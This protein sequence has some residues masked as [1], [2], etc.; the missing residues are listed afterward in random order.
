MHQTTAFRYARDTALRTATIAAALVAVLVIS[1]VGNFTSTVRA[2]EGSAAPIK[3]AIIVGPTHGATAE[4]LVQGEQFADQ[5][6]A[7]GM[8]VTRVFHP[9]ATWAAVKTAT[10]GAN[11]VVYYGHGNGWPSP[12]APFQENSKNGF[13]LNLTAGGSSSS[14]TYYGG[15]KLRESMRLAP[16]AVTVLYRACYASGNGEEG[17]PVP[18]ESI[19]LQRV[20]N[21]AAAFLSTEVGGSAVFALGPNQYV[22]Y[23]AQLMT[24]GMTMEDI[25]RVNSTKPGYS[26]S[27]WVGTSPIYAESTRTPGAQ[28]LLDPRGSTPSTRDYYRALSGELAMTTDTWRGDAPEVGY[29]DDTVAPEVTGLT[30]VQAGDT[31]PASESSVPVFTPN[32]DGISDTMTLNHSVSEPAYLQYAIRDAGGTKVRSFAGWTEGDAGSTVWDGKDDGGAY[33]DEG[34]YE[35]SVTP[36]DRA[37]N[38]GSQ[39]STS[40]K[41]LKSMKSPKAKPALFF[42]RDGDSIAASTNLTVSLEQAATLSWLVVDASGRPVRAL[43]TNQ[44]MGVG[45]QSMAWDGRDALGNYV[46][47]GIYTAIVTSTTDAGSYSHR[48]TVRVMPFNVTAPTWSGTAGSKVTFTIKSAEAL[49]GWPRIEI[50]QPGLSMYTGY[51]VRYSEKV[52]KFTVTFKSGGTSGP[53][54]IKIIGTD[55]GGGKQQKVYTFDLQ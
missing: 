20:D 38:V 10:Q 32:G 12:Y 27:G 53:V 16:N 43:V 46:P 4:Y 36:K 6:E 50:R 15:D 51:P 7:A 55:T 14:V 30:G 25:F 26:S 8:A 40:V 37:T 1:T 48:L 42:A 24:P 28:M 39:V 52:F 41:V 33:V 21:F 29:E 5:A 49:T 45:P 47:D 17:S 13:G 35:V 11:L 54:Q 2:A 19:A 31:V 9:Y 3:A 18:T 44:L 22:D 34:R 23:P